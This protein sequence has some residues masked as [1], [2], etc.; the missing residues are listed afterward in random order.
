MNLKT[1]LMAALVVALAMQIAACDFQTTKAL[2][3]SVA[4]GEEPQAIEQALAFVPTTDT[5]RI[6]RLE[7]L[8]ETGLKVRGQL[9]ERIAEMELF[10]H[11]QVNNRDP[12]GPDAL[13]ECADVPWVD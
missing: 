6:A 3:D 4:P 10:H 12:F 9:Q 13:P 2:I 8:V 7:V 11:C 5:D 1:R